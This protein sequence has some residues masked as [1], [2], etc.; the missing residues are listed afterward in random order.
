MRKACCML[1]MHAPTHSPCHVLLP[2]AAVIA[3]ALTVIV[4]G[5]HPVQF[6]YLFAVPTAA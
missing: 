3:Q 2:V 1:F 6:A 4:W 5:C